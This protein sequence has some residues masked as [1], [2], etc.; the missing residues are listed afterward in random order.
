MSYNKKKLI[1]KNSYKYIGFSEPKEVSEDNYYSKRKYFIVLL[2]EDEF[3]V[4]K[5]KK[6]YFGLR[7]ITNKIDGNE[8][9]TRRKERHDLFHPYFWEKMLL[10]GD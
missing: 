8:M 1:W 4:L 7:G 3:G 2:F 9:K 6:I 5:S 10:N